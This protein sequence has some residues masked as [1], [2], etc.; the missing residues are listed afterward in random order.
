MSQKHQQLITIIA[1]AALIGLG[2][3]G[4]VKKFTHLGRPA[5]VFQ[6][7]LPAIYTDSLKI[8]AGGV[9]LSIKPVNA[10]PAEAKYGFGKAGQV[11]YLKA[12]P[13]TD[14]RQT[15][16]SSKIKEEII[17][18]KPGHPVKFSYEIGLDNLRYV[19]DEQG[20][21]N[22][23]ALTPENRAEPPNELDKIF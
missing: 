7:K 10:S 22:F 8:F 23:Y 15:I 21:F 19:K 12:Y 4:L 18:Q 11:K 20:N 6:L 3:F 16:Y 2:V 17:L 13:E 5:M 9:E 1:L 14:V